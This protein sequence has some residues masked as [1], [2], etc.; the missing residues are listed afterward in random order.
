MRRTLLAV[1][2]LW[3][4]CGG[5]S[6]SPGCLSDAQICQF[7]KGTSTRADVQAK[8]G[9]AQMYLGNDAAIY[10]CQ[11]VSGNAVVHNDLVSFNFD[12]KGVLEDIVVVRQGSGATPPPACAN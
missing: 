11:E 7:K 2:A 5:E 9:N 1:A 6:S 3:L 12:D 4:A 10:V 8:L